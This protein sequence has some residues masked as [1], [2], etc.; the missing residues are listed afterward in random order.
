MVALF[1]H[2]I[3]IKLKVRATGFDVKLCDDAPSQQL[4]LLS[5]LIHG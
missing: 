4:S 1:H 2:N 5:E 3:V